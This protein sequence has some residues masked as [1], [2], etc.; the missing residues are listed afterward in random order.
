MYFDKNSTFHFFLNLK[1]LNILHSL[2]I[3]KV[4][5][6]GFVKLAIHE[7]KYNTTCFVSWVTYLMSMSKVI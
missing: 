3:V 1:A 5:K 6:L 2:S 7:M 4:S